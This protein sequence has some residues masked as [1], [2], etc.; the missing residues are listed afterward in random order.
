MNNERVLRERARPST[1]RRVRTTE[2]HQ[3]GQRPLPLALP[4]SSTAIYDAAYTLVKSS[5]VDWV[6][7]SVE[8]NTFGEVK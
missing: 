4:G 8:A 2:D 3:F 7:D 6:V 1:A 5:N